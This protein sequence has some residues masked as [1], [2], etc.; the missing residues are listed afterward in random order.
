VKRSL[1]VLVVEDDQILRETIGEV[2][3]DDGHD[4]RVAEDGQEALAQLSAWDPE[5]VI[6]DL[7]MPKMNA[8]EFRDAQR[9][10]GTGSGAQVLVLSAVPDVE[11]AAT[12]LGA[13]AWLAKPFRLDELV[14]VVDDLIDR[15]LRQ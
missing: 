6:L 5:L 14:A 9:R 10:D 1:K 2:M 3:S 7:M 8:Y 13:D 4:V 11:R 15:R 12:E